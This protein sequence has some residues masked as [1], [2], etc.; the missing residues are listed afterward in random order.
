MAQLTLSEVIAEAK[1]IAK[2]D[3]M[4]YFE[5]KLNGSDAYCC[6]FAWVNIYGIRANSKEGKELKALG[7]KKDDYYKSFMV[8]NPSEFGGQNIDTK[9]IGAESFAKVL[10]DY[11]FKAYAS[12]RLD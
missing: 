5:E 10:R 6:G 11:G 8:W 1:R 3:A 12:S 7:I 2:K 9:Y 4:Q